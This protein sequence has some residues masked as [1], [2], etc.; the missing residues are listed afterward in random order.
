MDKVQEAAS[1]S[2]DQEKTNLNIGIV[3]PCSSG[4]T[5]L[6]QGLNAAGFTARHIAQEHSFVPDMWQRISHPDLLIFL[7][8]SFQISQKRR[9]LDWQEN[10]FKEQQ[11][12]LAHARQYADLVIYTD[13]LS[14]AEVLERSLTFLKKK[15]GDK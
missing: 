10:D 8:V 14:V 3:G 15:T 7:D 13:Q 5:T 12:R 6:I 1:R 4:K 11:R 2:P 9:P